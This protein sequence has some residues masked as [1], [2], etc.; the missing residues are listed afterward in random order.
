[1]NVTGYVAVNEEEKFIATVHIVPDVRR[2]AGEYVGIMELSNGED[3]LVKKHPC[4]NYNGSIMK[5]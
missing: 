3:V 2:Y 4:G 5:E 1:M